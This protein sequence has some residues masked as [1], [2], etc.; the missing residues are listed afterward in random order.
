MNFY[1]MKFAPILRSR[2]RAS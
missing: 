1:R 2:D